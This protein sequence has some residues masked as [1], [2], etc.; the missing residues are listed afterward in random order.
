MKYVLSRIVTVL[1]LN[2]AY[3]CMAHT[4]ACNYRYKLLLDD[5]LKHTK[6][7]HMEYVR[8]QS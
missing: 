2:T 7:T 1:I 5:L 3:Y 4:N 6:P 8:L